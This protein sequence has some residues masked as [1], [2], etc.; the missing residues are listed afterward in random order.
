MDRKISTL[1]YNNRRVYDCF[2]NIFTDDCS[3]PYLN[4]PPINF[5]YR[6]HSHKRALYTTDLL[7]SV[8][9]VASESY[10][11]TLI[12]PSDLIYLLPSDDLNTLH[13]MNMD[14]TFQGRVHRGYCF[15]NQNLKRCYKRIRLYFFTCSDSNTI[16][17]LLS[18]VFRINSET[19]TVFLEHQ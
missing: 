1:E 18:W 3:I 16:F 15:R 10:L 4:I 12:T 17:L 9:S 14:V 13:V 11:S 5:N 8:I 19:R 6:P 2:N 7:P